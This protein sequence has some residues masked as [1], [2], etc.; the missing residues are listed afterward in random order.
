ME[1]IIKDCFINVKP[2]KGVNNVLFYYVNGLFSYF[3]LWWHVCCAI[4]A[5]TLAFEPLLL[6]QELT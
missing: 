6:L 5:E 2:S 3:I 1:E 4:A